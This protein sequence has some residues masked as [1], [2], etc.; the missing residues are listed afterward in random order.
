MADDDTPVINS[1]ERN[2]TDGSFYWTDKIFGISL[3]TIEGLANDA[4]E[5]LF[6]CLLKGRLNTC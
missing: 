2:D 3:G 4:T 6:F 1:F 5:A